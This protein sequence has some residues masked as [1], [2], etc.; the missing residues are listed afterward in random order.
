LVWTKSK[1]D[2]ASERLHFQL[3]PKDDTAHPR[4]DVVWPRPQEA[5]R[6]AR[7]A[8]AGVWGYSEEKCGVFISELYI[9][10]GARV[11]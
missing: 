6:E 5:R 8:L 7:P 2:L 1:S 11:K 9:A 3:A 10:R 4:K